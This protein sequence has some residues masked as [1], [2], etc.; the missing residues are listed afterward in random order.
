M[1]IDIITLHA[2][3]NYGSVLQ[4]L[5]TQEL[6]RKYGCDVTI[7]DYIRENVKYENLVKTWSRGNPIKAAAI[8][9]TIQRWK[10]VFRGF[11]KEYLNLSEKSYTTST[12][13]ENYPFTA[14]AFCTG[15]DQVWNSMWNNGII[16]SMY[17]DF[18]PDDKFRFSF[19]ASFGQT[20]LTQDEV[21]TKAYI[22]RY[23]FISVREDSAKKIIEEQYRY[24]MATH[25]VD[26][27]VCMDANFW[28]K[29]SSVSVMKE[30]YIL[31]YNLNRSKEFDA[32]AKE[33]S[34]RTG[35]KLV[36]LCTRYDQFLRN[37]KSILV[38]EVTEFIS[39]IDNAKYVLTDSFHATAFSMN[40]N[41]EPICVYPSEFGGRL[42]SFLKLTESQHRHIKGYDDFDVI[43][44]PVDFSNVNRILDLERNK[45]DDYLNTV[46]IAAKEHCR[47][48][49]CENK[50]SL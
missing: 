45:V 10:K 14:D 20:E 38:P 33:L 9:P 16:P 15:S 43:N 36:R 6:F 21:K 4:A 35:L 28:R 26:P 24:P 39:L 31:I 41:T 17:L 40:L 44:R 47:K 5:A 19:S 50:N 18:I 42:D 22:D 37:G 30:D 34:K 32:Y 48:D 2:V 13:F 49:K 23:N 25:L 27:T 46:F 11:C 3:Q 7:I 29:Y 12:D 1:K 8:F